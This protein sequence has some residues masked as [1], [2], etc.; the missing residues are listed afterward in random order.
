MSQEIKKFELYSDNG[1]AYVSENYKEKNI[2]YHLRESANAFTIRFDYEV[3]YSDTRFLSIVESMA[4][5]I[6]KHLSNKKTFIESLP[7]KFE[8]KHERS[9]GYDY[10]EIKNTV[11]RKTC[12]FR[13]R[14]CV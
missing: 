13:Q 11:D 7:K 6:Q 9:S 4:R 1:E 12:G 2:A 8:P 5:I 10:N 3:V 14:L